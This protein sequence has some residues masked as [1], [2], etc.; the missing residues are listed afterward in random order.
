[1]KAPVITILEKPVDRYVTTK[2]G[3]KQVWSQRASL[4]TEKMRVQIDVDVDGP[5]SAYEVGV[6]YEWDVT[7]DLIPGRFGPELAR[8]MSLVKQAAK[9]RTAA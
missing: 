8:R 9:V 2:N 7:E 3:Q 6:S 4:E 5:S 1:M